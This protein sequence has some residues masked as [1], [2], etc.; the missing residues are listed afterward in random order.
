[1]GRSLSVRAA[2]RWGTRWTFTARDGEYVL[3]NETV[4]E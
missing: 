4:K 3:G 1:M 2:N